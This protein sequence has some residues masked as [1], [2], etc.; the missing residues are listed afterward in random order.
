M[1]KEVIVY[2][3]ETDAAAGPYRT[4]VAANCPKVPH[5]IC[6]NGYKTPM[7]YNDGIRIWESMSFIE[8]DKLRFGFATLA[9]L[10]EWF[11]APARQAF[12]LGGYAVSMYDTKDGT[13]LA[14]KK[15]VAFEFE[16]A[17]RLDR[18]PLPTEA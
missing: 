2:R 9:Q 5:D 14:G 11:H 13:V 17:E 16:K 6:S 8:R 15:Q 4:D 18:F 1:E 10:K 3:V 12:A 7:P